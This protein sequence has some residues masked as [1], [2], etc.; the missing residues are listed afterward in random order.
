MHKTPQLFSWA[1]LHHQQEIVRAAENLRVSHLLN[2]S[3]PT[4]LSF[5]LYDADNGRM[6]K[7]FENLCL[8]QLAILVNLEKNFSS[9]ISFQ[10][11]KYLVL[12]TN[13]VTVTVLIFLLAKS[14]PNF[15]LSPER[16]LIQIRMQNI[17][18]QIISRPLKE[19]MNK[20]LIFQTED[21]NTFVATPS[22]L[23][24]L[25]LQ[26]RTKPNPPRPR[27]CSWV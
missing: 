15:C 14:A 2:T 26:S 11:W 19:P 9:K 3:F 17:Q 6:R 20:K 7:L 18:R 1:N 5:H 13:S 4:S 12:S 8:Q 27:V 23:P 25:D 10:S 16:R 22:F 21:S 24:F